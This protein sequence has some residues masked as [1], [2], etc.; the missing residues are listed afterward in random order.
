MVNTTRI[1]LEEVSAH[2]T[3]PHATNIIYGLTKYAS[4]AKY[5]DIKWLNG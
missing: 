5:N 2:I 1:K 3:L 4:M